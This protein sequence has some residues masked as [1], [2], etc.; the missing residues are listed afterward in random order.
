MAGFEGS[1]AWTLDFG[2]LAT[3]VTGTAADRRPLRLAP[4]V[5]RLTGPDRYRVLDTRRR[6]AQIRARRVLGLIDG[7]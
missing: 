7:E 4:P 6:Q 5:R 1:L 2:E 3:R